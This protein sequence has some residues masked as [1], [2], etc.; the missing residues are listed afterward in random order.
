MASP[1]P[2]PRS[3]YTMAKFIFLMST[4][5]AE[6]W[7]EGLLGSAA[8]KEEGPLTLPKADHC[9]KALMRGP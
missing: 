1:V 3:I 9:K 8:V 4:H 7:G 5:N 6:E 2:Q